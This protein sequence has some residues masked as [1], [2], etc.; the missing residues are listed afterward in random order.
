[1]LDR[2][3]EEGQ[4][5]HTTCELRPPRHVTQVAVGVKTRRLDD[6]RRHRSQSCSRLR[7]STTAG[8]PDITSPRRN[9]SAAAGNWPNFIG[10]AIDRLKREAE[11][12]GA[13]SR[14]G[15]SISELPFQSAASTP[16]SDW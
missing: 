5:V 7:C 13:L 10:V 9:S 4:R 15:R 16:V 3:D 1:D 14:F 12:H 11:S 2:P 8:W 6:D